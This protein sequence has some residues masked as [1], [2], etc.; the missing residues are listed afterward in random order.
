MAE[1]LAETIIS[2]SVVACCYALACCV[3]PTPEDE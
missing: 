1:L 3:R 2:L